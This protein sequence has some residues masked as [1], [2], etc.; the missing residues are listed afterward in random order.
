MT[1]EEA[2]DNLAAAYDAKAAAMLRAIE[3]VDRQFAAIIAR[4]MRELEVARER[5]R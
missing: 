4:R 2:E 1:P 5:A 3:Q